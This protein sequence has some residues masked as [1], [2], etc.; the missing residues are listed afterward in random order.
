MYFARK[1]KEDIE[2]MRLY[3]ILAF[4][5]KTFMVWPGANNH[6]DYAK[7]LFGWIKH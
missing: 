7:V 2:K 5:Y 4:I 1:K 3:F 6:L